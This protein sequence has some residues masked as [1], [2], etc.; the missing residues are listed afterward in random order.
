MK[1]ASRDHG[2]GVKRGGIGFALIRD[3]SSTRRRPFG[4][5]ALGRG[6]SLAGAE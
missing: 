2:E 4:D 1:S 6:R 3:R 5:G